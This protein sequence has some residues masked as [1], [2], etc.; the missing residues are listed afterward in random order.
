MNATSK[1]NVFILAGAVLGLTGLSG[2]GAVPVESDSGGQV[3]DISTQFALDRPGEITLRVDPGA[4]QAEIDTTEQLFDLLAGGKEDLSVTV[5]GIRVLT[6]VE[7][8]RLDA[9]LELGDLAA[10]RSVQVE[11][12]CTDIPTGPRS[13]DGATTP[14]FPCDD[15]AHATSTG[16]I[17]MGDASATLARAVEQVLASALPSQTIDSVSVVRDGSYFRVD[18]DERVAD[19]VSRLGQANAVLLDH[20]LLSTAHTNGEI[21]SIQFT[22][23]GNCRRWATAVGGDQCAT[24]SLPI[25]LK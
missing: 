6:P 16:E 1:T 10:G 14:I 17:V 20:A 18:I 9:R 7:R 8:R 25:S 23:D 15:E 24:V 4:W 5:E 3:A 12:K 22:V 21:R 19:Q 11:T 13:E 2:A